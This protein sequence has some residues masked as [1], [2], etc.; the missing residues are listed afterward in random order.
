MAIVVTFYYYLLSGGIKLDFFPIQPI[1][2]TTARA[3]LLENK[4]NESWLS[5]IPGKG[6][7]IDEPMP[8]G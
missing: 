3:I 5:S 6:T 8:N 1:L 2:H 4:V 7:L